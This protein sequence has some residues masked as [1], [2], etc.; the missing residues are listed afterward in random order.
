MS[1]STRTGDAGTTG[2][3]YN[4]RVSKCHP[5]V[6]A[7]GVVDELNTALGLVRASPVDEEIGRAVTGFQKD[8]V[9]MMGEMA[10]SP[11]DL[12]RYFKD[13]FQRVSRE[14]V[15]VLDNWVREI[16]QREITFDGWA[17]PGDTPASAFLD[18][19]RTTCRRA[20][21]QVCRAENSIRHYEIILIY[22]NR[23]SDVLWLFARW[24]ERPSS[25]NSRR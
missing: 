13:G 4:R 3:M 6:E 19:A 1:I 10:T 17:T 5:Q 2:L 7:Y 23:L 9:V 21:R 25:G 11:E 16:E 24:M 12:D 14:M 18:H 22:L 15:D 20:E 8:L